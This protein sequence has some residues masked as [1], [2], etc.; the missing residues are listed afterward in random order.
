MRLDDYYMRER[1][2]VRSLSDTYFGRKF[3]YHAA[4]GQLLTLTVPPADGN[5]YAKPNTKR[6]NA[7]D[8][9]SGLARFPTLARTFDA[10]DR[11]GSRLFVAIQ[12]ASAA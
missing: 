7:G 3:F 2:R 8:D 6:T 11:L 10:L 12:Q 1:L 9:L 4:D 5:A